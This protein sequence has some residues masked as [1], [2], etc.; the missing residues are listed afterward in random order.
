M[1]ID[2]PIAEI[3]PQ[4]REEIATAVAASRRIRAASTP[5]LV[6]PAPPA[7]R[8]QTGRLNRRCTTARPGNLPTSY[9]RDAT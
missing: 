4:R 3:G 8:G 2:Y 1:S 6:G 7:R 9:R 5:L